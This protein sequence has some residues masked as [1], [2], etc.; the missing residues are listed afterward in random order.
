[1][2]TTLNIRSTSATTAIGDDILLRETS[3]SRL[4]FRPMLVQNPH[5]SRHSVK[6]EFV[7]Q[8]KKPSGD[9]EDYKTLNLSQLKD[10][11]WIKLELHS[12]E[13]FTLVTKL[14]NYYGI[15]K[16]YGIRFGERQFFLTDSNFRPLI[17]QILT[18][19]DVFRR[20]LAI[21][22][23]EILEKLLT[24]IGTTDETGLI[25]EKLQALKID[26]LKKINS[27]IGVS[28]LKKLL[29]IWNASR[30]NSSEEF[31]QSTFE[32]H[33]WA[34]SQAFSHPVVVLRKKAYVGGKVIGNDRGNVVDFLYQ[35]KI[36]SNV[37]LIEIKTPTTKLL[38]S[39][40][41]QNAYSLSPDLSGSVTQLSVYKDELQKSFYGLVRQEQDQF[42]SLNPQCLL[43]AGCFELE[44]MTPAGKRSFEL[45]RSDLKHIQII[46]FDEL[47]EKI[48]LL[49]RLL[50]DDT[51]R[52]GGG[53]TNG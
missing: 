32:R 47:F 6:G 11:E 44:E 12:S 37:S 42:L 15:F 9:W 10:G 51:T 43:I 24:W 22:G 40:Y 50:E 35:N 46:T 14:D 39:Q 20:L 48:N 18:N 53:R 33:A 34:I 26:S 27:L 29:D 19:K 2:D 8:A 31:W 49:L 23:P 3:K 45:F 7:F 5:D 36:T 16:K 13:L 17:D 30:R 21:G 52:D 41:R 38:G 28:N 4:A 25:V 1:M